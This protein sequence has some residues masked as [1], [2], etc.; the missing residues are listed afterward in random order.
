MFLK[1]ITQS[2]IVSRDQRTMQQLTLLKCFLISSTHCAM[3]DLRQTIRIN[4]QWGSMPCRISSAA[5]S[6]VSDFP[7][8]TGS[9]RNPPLKMDF[10]STFS[11]SLPLACQSLSLV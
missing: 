6:A 1:P 8:P 11:F 4:P 5:V 2:D 10:A 9:Q 7:S 3:Q